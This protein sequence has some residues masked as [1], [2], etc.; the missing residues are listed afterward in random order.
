MTK[1][2]KLATLHG[3]ALKNFNQIQSVMREERLQNLQDRR[4]AF[5]AGAQ[6]EGPLGEQFENKPRAE[7][8]KVALSLTRIYSEYRNNRIDVRFS[9]RYDA[10]DSLADTC[11]GLFRADEQ[12]SF[13][14]EA[15]DN[16]FEEGTSGGFGAF[17]LRC[18]YENDDDAEQDAQRIKIEPIFDADSS[19]FFDLNAKR[20]DKSD[21]EFCY[22]L[23]SMTP[24]EFEEEF[25]KAPTS[26]PKSIT[27]RYFDWFSP[28]VV[29]VAEY[30]VKEEKK[31]TII[32]FKGML[33]EIEKYKKEELDET[34]LAELQNR[35]F[36]QDNERKIKVTKVHKYLMDGSEILE[37]CGYIAGN[38]IPIIPFY[39]KR[40]FVDN[41]ERCFGHVRIVKDA[42]RLKN[43]QIS[44]LMEISSLSSYEKPIVTP[45]QVQGL[46]EYWIND[47]VKNY[48]YMLI[49]PITD[50]NGNLQTVAPTAYTKPPTVPPALAALVSSS[51]EDLNELLGSQQAGEQIAYSKTSGIAMELMQNRLDMQS[52]L[53]ISNFA[54]A[55]RRA[56]E[57][58]LG[59]AKDIFVEQGR[60]LKTIGS[61]DEVDYIELMQPYLGESGLEIRNDISKAKF[62]IVVEIGASSSSKRASTVRSLTSM[63]AITQDPDTQ[64]VLNAAA[65]MNMEGEGLT[66]VN[67]Y[68]RKKLVKMGVLKPTE[69]EAQELA[70]IMQNQ[71]PDPQSVYLQAAAKEAEAKAVKAQADTE[72]TLADAER[73]KVDTVAILTGLDREGQRHV[74]ETAKKLA[75]LTSPSEIK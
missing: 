51:N 19:V 37:D 46:Q 63:M 17:R 14:E 8:N 26:M 67:Q 29:Y 32:T 61:Q 70:E 73:T 5:I 44:K 43:M 52:F 22:V 18:D 27:Q 74:I 53:Y 30:Y 36:K 16:A 10:Q 12:D 7:L 57:V 58:W 23:S 59:M 75:D 35:G 28:N 13:A 54:K 34:K 39:G 41:V 38:N 3:E 40:I 21:A 68:F 1:S 15:Y 25:G 42:Q 47:N 71:Q 4:F 49:N 66:E 2:E 62:D 6:W 72:K 20:Q 65:M 69:A 55:K 48:P 50:A 31:E 64:A 9:G 45:E 24:E 60:V 11:T 56:C 33:G